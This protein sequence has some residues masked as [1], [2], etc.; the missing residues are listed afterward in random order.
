[1]KYKRTLLFRFLTGLLFYTFYFI[2]SYKFLVTGNFPVLYILSIVSV[3]MYLYFSYKVSYLNMHYL[4]EFRKEL[5]LKCVMIFI[6]YGFVFFVYKAIP[7]VFQ[8]ENNLLF[9]FFFFS[10]YIVFD[11]VSEIAIISTSY[12]KSVNIDLYESKMLHNFDIEQAQMM[13][14]SFNN[15]YKLMKKPSLL[16][17]IIEKYLFVT[18][19]NCF[20]NHNNE[21]YGVY[22]KAFYMKLIE[23]S[24]ENQSFFSKR[25]KDDLNYI[26]DCRCNVV[27]ISK[28]KFEFIDHYGSKCIITKDFSKEII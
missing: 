21:C 9:V 25:I 16:K 7:F 6:M 28:S 18:V 11:V 4:F 5:V 26:L 27:C 12:R 20:V 2:A 10:F 23:M 22:D 14:S 13:N 3:M 15:N 1:M 8:K 19:C 24:K 17:R